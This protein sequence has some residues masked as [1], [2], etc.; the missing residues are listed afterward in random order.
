MEFYPGQTF[1]ADGIQYRVIAIDSIG[2]EKYRIVATDSNDRIALEMSLD[3]LDWVKVDIDGQLP[4]L[5]DFY[6]QRGTP[7]EKA[8]TEQIYA[9]FPGLRAAPGTCTTR[10]QVRAQLQQQIW[11][12]LKSSAVKLEDIGL[13]LLETTMTFFACGAGNVREGNECIRELLRGFEAEG[14][15]KLNI[16][17]DEAEALMNSEIKQTAA[18]ETLN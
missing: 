16:M 17:M 3:G 13:V 10:I 12:M 7:E 4:A 2:A 9:R 18:G 11:E 14:C 6:S 5:L 1:E 15:R 8:F